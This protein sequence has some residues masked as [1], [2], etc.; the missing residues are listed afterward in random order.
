[1]IARLLE[2]QSRALV[3]IAFALALAGIIA[4]LGL[5]VG[6][7]PQV[8]FP[9]V[10]VDLDAGSRPA[11]QTA[12]LV[13]RPI[14]EAVRAIPGVLDVRSETTRGSAQ[15]SIDFGWGRD[16]VAS[17]LLVE[18]AVARAVTG[19]PPGTTYGV[20]RRDPTVFPILSYALVSTSASPV[21]LQDLAR[22]QITPLLS[23]VPGLARVA[24]QGGETA[25]V[26]VLADPSRLAGRGLA[27]SDVA[28][29]I[30]NANVLS[31]VGHV[32]DRGRLSLVLADHSLV[33]AAQVAD[34]VVRADPAGMVRVRDVASVVD[35]VVPR[36][37]RI[38]EDGR[39]AVLVNVYQQPDG[40]SVQ[41]TKAVAAKLAAFALPPG[42]K[43]VNWYDQ[44]ELVSQSVA[45]V[46]DAVLIGLVLAAIVLLV[47]LRSWARDAGRGH[48]R[49][50]DAGG[51][52]AG[53]QRPQPQLQHHDA[54]RDRRRGRAADRRR[55]RNGRTHRPARR[56]GPAR[57]HPRRH[58]RRAAGDRGFLTPR[59][60]K[61]R[62]GVRLR[63]RA[64]R[65]RRGPRRRGP[66]GAQDRR[67]RWRQ[68]AADRSRRRYR[69]SDRHGAIR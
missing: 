16:M 39:P 15:L 14:E 45:S 49:S 30:R 43:L 20:R 38:V 64:A 13:T 27:M 12:L 17:T 3:L 11:D 68:P 8:S 46:R 21:A 6:L 1:M 50:G 54:G 58:R 48:R 34:V 42:V 24:V 19:L 5:P 61:R 29:A 31:A 62:L 63:R 41:I 4:G 56:S 67:T 69:G 65:R 18:T 10:V 7:F 40:N 57:R 59:S 28:T 37:T 33:S 51:D 9:R 32:Q 23:G 52:G 26:E 55:D 47:F 2:R 35:G 53:A 25:E 66:R 44:S 22:Y 36:F 60:P